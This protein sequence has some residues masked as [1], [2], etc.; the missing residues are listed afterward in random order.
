MQSFV[1]LQFI[2]DTKQF[3]SSEHHLPVIT[4]MMTRLFGQK[5]DYENLSEVDLHN[6]IYNEKTN[7]I[8]FPD[9]NPETIEMTAQEIYSNTH[10]YIPNIV[11]APETFDVSNLNGINYKVFHHRELK[12]NQLVLLVSDEL[13]FPAYRDLN[14]NIQIHNPDLLILVEVAPTL[15]EMGRLDAERDADLETK[16]IYVQSG[17]SQTSKEDQEKLME[18]WRQATDRDQSLEMLAAEAFILPESNDD[19]IVETVNV[20]D[21]ENGV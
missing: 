10:K 4:C 8:H 15:S 13:A 9:F 3:T 1:C 6:I 17:L 5:L 20:E 21:L 12:E 16:A 7:V 2:D 18:S 14:N 11:Y 19:V